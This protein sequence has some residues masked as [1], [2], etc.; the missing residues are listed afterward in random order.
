MVTDIPADTDPRELDRADPLARFRTQFAHDDDDAIYLDGNSL[1]RPPHRVRDA[2]MRVVDQEWRHEL[3]R[4][5]NHW[6]DLPHKVGDDLAASMLGARP[7]EVLIWDSTSVNLYK[8][9]SAVAQAAP[10]TRTV[11]VTDDDNFPTDQY[12]L[13]GVAEQHN[14]TV[15]TIHSDIDHG[16]DP[17]A[18]AA[19]VGKDTALVCLS[20]VAYRSGAIADMTA[21][22]EMVHASG[23]LMLWDLC[24]SVGSVPVD[25]TASGAD[26]A[27]GCTY[28]HLNAGPG[29]PAFLYVRQE[30]QPQLRQPIWGW[31]SQTNQFDMSG[32]YNP[33]PGVGGFAVGTPGIMGVAAVE[34]AVELVSEAGID[35]I[36]QKSL[37]LNAYAS[38]L[39]AAELTALGFTLA[40]PADLE[41]RGG[42][43]TVHHPQAWQIGQA[44]HGRYVIGDYREPDRIRL[45][46]APLYNSYSDIRSAV[47][48]MADIVAKGEQDRFDPTPGRVR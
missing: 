37:R 28:K 8:L 30:L 14:M 40:S 42:H 45:G 33:L 38:A 31:F 39:V 3:I 26:L 13:Q 24:H 36:R 23:A 48:V 18:L 16:V 43:L 21:I 15:R 7:G 44:M 46:F 34:A 19:A 12:I 1:G 2:I 6:I 20:H 11:I 25:L 47:S 32:D 29:A 27:V 17:A 4:A 41:K 9:A 10:K 22:T 5:W 35:A